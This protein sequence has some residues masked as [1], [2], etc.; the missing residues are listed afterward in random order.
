MK[1]TNKTKKESAAT[2][3]HMDNDKFV[4]LPLELPQDIYDDQALPDERLRRLGS[5]HSFSIKTLCAAIHSKCTVDTIK[6][7]IQTHQASTSIGKLLS[8]DGWPALYYAAERNSGGLITVLLQHGVEAKT[9]GTSFSIPLIAYAIIHGHIEARDT[10]DA[11]K[12]LL[13]AGCDPTT[14]PM[15]MWF[16]FLETPTKV[17]NPSIKVPTDSLQPSAWCTPRIR[18]ILAPSLH[19]THR[20]LLHL[21][22]G[23]ASLRPRML[24]I[25]KAHKMT[26][27]S[28]L[29]YFLIGQR[30][31]TDIV[32]KH[33][34]SHISLGSR[35][36]LVM[37]FAGP[38]GHGKTELARAMGD[39]LSV[40]TVVIDMAAC[41]DPRALFGVTAGYDRSWDGSKLNNF[42]AANSGKRSVVFLDEF[43]KTDQDL[44]NA[45]LLVTQSGTYFA[46]S[47]ASTC[48]NVKQANTKIDATTPPWTAS[49]LSGLW[50]PTSGMTSSASTMLN[51]SSVWMR[52]SGMPQT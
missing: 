44:R 5:S 51:I 39:L 36:P 4:L 1:K 6:W 25:S 22:H 42:L 12:L 45:L 30:P 38:S 17:P 26:E 13:A 43:D 24:Q 32:M 19:L 28:K 14:I 41:R 7:Y 40:K 15:D 16:K 50:R 31:A 35:T 33:V 21:A 2:F 46:L 20:Y 3:P 9:S 10:S 29:P 49:R 8:N 18:S 34:Y 37:G 23:L 27:L 52:R 48:A 11:V 47:F